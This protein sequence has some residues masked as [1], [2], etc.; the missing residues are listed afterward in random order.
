MQ[1][2]EED[3]VRRAQKGDNQAFAQ[4][5]EAYFVRVY[6]YV[7][8]RV[9]D[10]TEAEDV[11]EEVFL[12]ALSAM[13]AFRWQNPSWAPWLFRIAHNQVVDHLRQKSKIRSV[14]L[15]QLTQDDPDPVCLAELRMTYQDVTAAAKRLSDAQRQVIALRF[16]SQLSLAETARALGKSEGAIKALQHSALVALRQILTEKKNG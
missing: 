15:P 8:I 5:Y 13:P 9:G 10:A 14:S 16:A 6:R 1:D 12:K 11:T 4:L 2:Q 3:L 7:A